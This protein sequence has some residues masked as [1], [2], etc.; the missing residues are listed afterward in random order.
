MRELLLT[1]YGITDLRA[2]LGFDAG[3]GPIVGAL[4]AHPYTGVVVLG[5]VKPED[6]RRARL[7]RRVLH[8]GAAGHPG[9]YR[10]R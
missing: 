9:R 10:G 7:G 8:P 1:W 4:K 3:D 2:S 6:E 5:Y